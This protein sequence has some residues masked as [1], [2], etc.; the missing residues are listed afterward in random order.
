[1]RIATHLGYCIA[2]ADLATDEEWAAEPQ[3]ATEGSMLAPQA[4]AAKVSMELDEMIHHASQNSGLHPTAFVSQDH[5]ELMAEI[6]NQLAE[7][8]RSINGGLTADT[9]MTRWETMQD[10]Q[11]LADNVA[12]A[13]AQFER[14]VTGSVFASEGISA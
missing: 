7:V 2:W 1:V 6:V 5:V 11:I 14:E 8:R 9:P 4:N 3:D 13:S 10:L 12:Y